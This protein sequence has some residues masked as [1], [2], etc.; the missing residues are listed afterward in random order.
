MSCYL[1]IYKIENATWV[2]LSSMKIK[3]TLFTLLLLLNSGMLFSQVAIN[4]D[5]SNP[6]NSAMLDVKSNNKG[7][8]PPRMTHVEM[9][10]IPNPADGLIV[11]CTDCS[12]DGKGVLSIF[13]DGNWYVLNIICLSPLSP[14][15]VTNVPSA[16][17]VVWDWKGVPYATGYKWNTSNDY[18]TATLMDTVTTKT[19][20]GL[21][22]N[23]AYTRYV[24]AYNNCGNSLPMTIT[25]T[26]LA[27]SIPTLTT[28]VA[29]SIASTSATS[30]GNITSDGGS[31][32]TVRGVCWGTAPD[33]TTANSKTTDG[34]GNGTFR[35]NLTVL[36]E[37]TDYY[38]RAYATNSSGT[39]YGNEIT[40]KTLASSG[41]VTVT[42][43]DG[44][45]YKTITIGSQT[46][47]AENL[48]TTKYRNGDPISNETGSWASLVTG[49][50][51]WYNNDVTNKV[52]YGGLYNWYAVADNRNIAPVGWHV[53]TD[54]EWTTLTTFLGGENV[55]GGK[56]K[57]TGMTNWLSPNT[58]AT[59]SS[60]FT[61]LPGGYRNYNNITF[62]SVG[63]YGHWWSSTANDAAGAW[64]RV[65]YYDFAYVGRNPT[66]KQGGVS[67][68]CVRDITVMVP[69]LST[70]VASAITSTTATTG[71]NISSDGG[72][73]VTARG[74]CWGTTSN[75]TTANSKTTEGTGIGTFV[76][77]FTG[78]IENT[79]YHVKAYA[80]NSSGT[81]YG[82]EITFKTLAG[83][84]PLTVTD[85]DGNVYNTV[86]IGTQT[87][88]L[89]NLKTTKYRNGEGIPNVTVNA[90]W[91]AL[92][93]G[94]YCWY[95][96]DAPAYR[97]AYGALYNWYA[98]ADSRNIAPVGWH[99]P[100]DAEWTTLTDYLGGESVA[101]GK[102][103]EAGTTHWLTPNTGATNSSGFT[104]LPGGYRSYGDGTFL[105]GGA[106]VDGISVWW[107]CTAYNAT[108]AWYRELDNRDADVDHN[109]INKRHGFSVRGVKDSPIAPT[110]STTVISAI[111]PT[112]ATSG[113]NI[114]S[115]GGS[116][117]TVRGVCW[118]TAP[119]PTTANS[120]TTDGTGVG[121]FASSLTGLTENTTYYV[122]A[123]ATN[124]SG[125]AYGNEITFKT[126][127]NSSGIIF[128]P[129]LTYG[130]MTDNDANEY[131]TITIGTQTWMAENL[132]T[133]K[134]RNGDPISNVTAN[135]AWAAL[136]T[137]AYCWYNNDAPNKA[138]YGGLYNW[139][140][141]ADSRNIAP[142]G[143][144]VPTD[145][146]WTTLLTFLGGESVAGSKLKESGTGHWT[147]PNA[148]ATNS[149]GF[150]GLPGGLR[151]K[152][153]A[154]FTQENTNGYWWSST[155]FDAT[156]LW[157]R[158]L[159]YNYAL[160]DHYNGY[161]KQYGLSVRC[162]KD[163]PVAPTITTTVASAIASTTATSGGNI[164]S[165]GGS[166]V[167][168][169]GVCWGTASN[170][171]TTNSKTTDGTGVGSFASSLTGLTE[172]TTYYVRAYAT[173]S[174]GTGYGN[175]VTFKTLA[176]NVTVTDI[177][178]NVYNT[179][180]IGTQTWMV[181]NLKTTKYRNGDL[182][183]NVTVD[184]AWVALN[185]GAYCWYNNDAATYKTTYGAMYNWYAVA[186]GRNIAP[187]GW[188]VPSDAEWT[189]LTTF[190]GG[191]SVAGGKLKETGSA[192]WLTANTGASNSSGF[193]AIPGGLRAGG[194][195]FYHIGYI[196][197][198]LSSS[199][200]SN[201][202]FWYRYMNSNVSDA[203][204][205]NYPKVLGYSVRCLRD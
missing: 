67:V 57:E 187:I 42:D 52:T 131:K 113:G 99:V 157:G 49:A 133:T 167:T 61:A 68:R 65:L 109:G 205:S 202:D 194:G 73:A 32:V 13:R 79:T 12:E 195:S 71:G 106:S 138:T 94:A 53:A 72:S 189:T 117:V 56:L 149:S 111:A 92:A 155:A 66:F 134:Y 105:D 188:H 62:R 197:F 182:I 85:I 123:Y 128:N 204:R 112:T 141:I 114:T 60:G 45:V 97:A 10:A 198:W 140:A 41:P 88:M 98:V 104:A 26:T 166:A 158:C 196:G 15:I 168:V 9:N 170:P 178:G 173:N 29:S 11:Y 147:S 54:D 129:E 21:N 69:T 172:N 175:E 137:D 192:H 39:G 184:A 177:D 47:M 20:T 200:Y 127:G 93:T 36:T 101:G 27:C 74:V 143:W 121:S 14:I 136:T 38:L 90:S 118:G 70:T 153:T 203:F 82:N 63:Y 125:T 19:E 122:R 76:S 165:D 24:W 89:E 115:D 46:W 181:E 84:A 44:N 103:K 191:E 34:T 16:A 91:G 179:V 107:S 6:N 148:G 144:H 126:L 154:T 145:A 164:T 108:D 116:T 139:Y 59:N 58:G 95:N 2:N 163:S 185:T 86:T 64:Y 183:P 22:C 23:T 31:E 35:S 5:G 40:F 77:S 51:S 156:Y 78:L 174:S 30:G 119:N 48:K 130:T 120:K 3:F 180:T 33:P 37:N 151:D 146:E 7:L 1:I 186:D 43:I 169:R 80:T 124:S 8:L 55:A 25:Q 159:R 176:G 81:G 132:K 201:T 150:T 100:T 87:W 135:A 171:T 17:G 50:Y 28:T 152:L 96:N 110:L 142:T 190:L 199:E 161:I 18:G 102:L 83:S 75:P 162:I 193:T 4:I 160:V